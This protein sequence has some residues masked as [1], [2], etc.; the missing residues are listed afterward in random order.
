MKKEAPASQTGQQLGWGSNIQNA[1]LARAAELAL[2]HGDHAHAL[3]YAQRAAQ[4]SPTDPQIWFLLGYTARL[5]GRYG[6]SAEA[7]NR[8]LKLAPSSPSGMSGLAQ[9]YSLMGR[10]NEAQALLKKVL[11]VDPGQRD[12]WLVLADIDIHAGHYDDALD[13]L[14]KAERL[15]PDARSELLLAICY[16]HMKQL[17]QANRWLETA[18]RRAPN[19]SDVER[20]LAGYYRDTGDYAKAIDALKAIHDPHPD[21]VAEMAYTNQLDGR[22]D[23]SARLYEHA[24]NAMPHD[25]G[26]QLSAAQAQVADNNIPHAEDFLKRA[27]KIEPD[28]YRL[29]AIRGDI[30]QLQD[31]D[32]DAAREFQ[33]A[34]AQ[35][36]ASPV[37]GP[38]YPIQLHMNL[39]ALYQNLAESGKAQQ[40]LA[41]AEKQIAALNEE[42]P[43]RAG[44]L[45]L[46]ALIRMDAGQ[47]DSALA[48]MKESLALNP[49]DPGSLQL[50]GEVLMKMGRTSDAIAAYKKALSIDAKNRAAL[51]SLGYAERAAG[52]DQ[53]AED[54]FQQLAHDY[55]S[56]YVP[57]LALGDMYAERHQY[58]KAEEFYEQS[59]K[60]APKNPLIAAG[61]INVGVERHDLALAG[62]WVHRVSGAMGDNPQVMAEEERYYRFENQPKVS[63]DLGRRAIRYLPRNRDVVVYLGY[64]M[65]SLNQYQDLLALTQKYMDIF[66]QEPDIP[67]LAGYVYKHDGDNQNA[68]GAF[69][70]AIRRDPSTET[71]WVNRGYIYNNLDE[72]QLAAP[73]FEKAL[74]L[75]S[76]DGEAHL[77]LAYADLAL[78]HNFAALHQSDMAQAIIGDSGALHA[79][80]ATAYG[81]EGL[82]AKAITEYRAALKFTPSDASLHMSL[83]SVLFSERRYRDSLQ[84]LAAA[85]RLQ[86][87]NPQT[88][89]LEARDYAGLKD[90]ADTVQSIELA[91]G[92]ASRMPPPATP[93]S[94][95]ASDIYLS[96]GQ[97]WNTLGDDKAAMNSFGKALVS[98]GADR[99]GVRLAIGS[100]MAQQG[101]KDDAE[102]QIAL[103]QMEAQGH[104]TAAPT[105]AEYVQAAGILQQLHEY[106][107]SET[108]LDKAQAAGASDISVRVS[109][110]NGYLALGE[111]SRAAAELA[112][113]QQ[114]DDIRS[115]YAYLLAEANVYQQEHQNVRAISAFA[116]AASAAGDDQT[117]EQE[118]IQTGA[119]EGYALKSGVSVLTNV[120][121]QP[122]FEDSTVYELDAKTFGNPPAVSGA[123]IRTAELPPSRY[124]IDTEWTTAYHLHFGPVPTAGGFFQV[125]NARGL[126]SVPAIGV[127]NR[128]TNDYNFNFGVN[129][130]LHV[131]DAILTFN[132]GV[133][134]TVRRD[135]LSPRE[136]NQNLA[137]FFTYMNTSSLFHALSVS[138]WFIHDSGAFTE[139]PLDE[140]AV[141]GAIDFRVGSPWGK[142]AL[143]T[144]WGM[145]DQ[146]FTSSSLGNTENYYTSSYVGLTR[147]LPARINVEGLAE[148]LRSWRVVPFATGPSQFVVNSGTAQALRPAAT[149][150]FSPAP[151][152]QIR[153]SGTYEDT[154]SF[155]YYDMTQNGIAVSYMRPFGRTFNE[156]TGE[157]RFRYPVR[158]SAGLQEQTFLNIT[159]GRNQQFRPYVSITLF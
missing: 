122:L 76:K 35:L 15:R 6:Q 77:G 119:N 79:I 81:R 63:A 97:A 24:A 133:Q 110:A 11:A 95:R 121:Q 52:N 20:S 128:D 34:V 103:A 140:S 148:Y 30:A 21:V 150:D 139:L 39:E 47:P 7:F 125:R 72:P 48:D 65:L 32:D 3:E 29:H 86:P 123:T 50:D 33:Q 43:D 111:T 96:T 31:H 37:E 129:P 64:D 118:L 120:L 98:P 143:V 138:G 78:N 27:E 2:Q 87:R 28:S 156:D 84:E 146:H 159:Q 54:D 105:G 14:S 25:V 108:W 13:S 145:N 51:I 22:L 147:S 62:V 151:D 53:A 132:S 46:R 9:T 57:W 55:P 90:R 114:S 100:L 91:E 56:L 99:V 8:G 67:L 74:T 82:L 23:D 131:G 109:L 142:T 19:N 41:I 69:S 40:E 115:D 4:A 1:R 83:A 61:G 107:L 101:R 42:G 130:T 136:M 112:A 135:S 141:S 149:V 137:R 102:R 80:R 154:R 117:A 75:K 153:F 134:G 60:I 18:K 49:N 85:A 44:F 92:Y 70:E 104:E 106:T 5:N 12:D 38:L 71:A 26:L 58:K 144:G 16:E 93:S 152:W 68:V 88:W 73:D 126:I 157:V 66:P 94:P 158:F 36:P 59:Y 155:H 10:N 17:D 113:L 124:T 89:A 116:Q 45:R 127:V